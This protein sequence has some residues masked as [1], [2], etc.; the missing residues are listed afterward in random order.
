MPP[1]PIVI[2]LSPPRALCACRPSAPHAG[3]GGSVRTG[4]PDAQVR[5]LRAMGLSAGRVGALR[6]HKCVVQQDFSMRNRE[7]PLGGICGVSRAGAAAPAGPD[8][9]CPGQARLWDADCGNP[10]FTFLLSLR[11]EA[12]ERT[13]QR[14][15]SCTSCIAREQ[16]L[17]ISC[18][19]SGHGS[20]RSLRWAD[21][22]FRRSPRLGTQGQKEQKRHDKSG[23]Q[24]RGKGVAPRV[25]RGQAGT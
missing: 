24:I 15:R 5:G 16:S 17:R 9:A 7:P 11:S 10:F 25:L 14:A 22:G 20:R 2:I 3:R 12:R 4:T 13:A 8:T 6:K 21:K 1:I 19:G 18:R 23:T